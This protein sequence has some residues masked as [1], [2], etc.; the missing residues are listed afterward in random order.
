[1][2][3]RYLYTLAHLKLR[4]ISYRIFYLLRR[5]LL[6]RKLNFY[7]PEK[8]VF[9]RQLVFLPFVPS[10]DSF[11]GSSFTFLNRGLIFPGEVSWNFSE[12]G[13]LWCYNLNYFDYLNN[14]SMGSDVGLHLIRGFIGEN[15]SIRDGFEPYPVSL[16]I[17]NW[18]KFLSRHGIREERIDRSLFGQ[19]RLL[20]DNLEYHL[21]GNHLLENGFALLFAAIYFND[22]ELYGIATKILRAELE[23]QV[24]SDGAHFELSP[25]YHQI[26]LV[27]LLDCVNLIQ[28]NGNNDGLLEL[29]RNKA[30]LMLGW[31][32]QMSFAN[33][34]MPLLNDA[35]DGIAPTAHDLCSY[36]ERLGIEA[37]IVPLGESGYRKFSRAAYEMIV[38]VGKIGP[39]YIPGHAHSDT[40]SFI[41][42]LNGRPLIVD[43]GTSTYETNRRREAERRT[44]AHN[45][46]VVDDVDQSEVWGSFRVAQRAYVCNL[47]ESEEAIGAAHSGYQR[48]G[49]CHHRQFKFGADFISITDSIDSSSRHS[50]KAFFHFHPD[51]SIRLLDGF[52]S[53]GDHRISFAGA[54]CVK[55]EDYMFAPQFNCLVPAKV[56]EV[57]FENR[58]QTDIKV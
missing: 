53:A 14:E 34:D 11:D 18:I 51:V 7:E 55:L 15:D 3:K 20:V 47:V 42:Y 6:P 48:I 9:S 27:R 28:H 37:Y 23:E 39:D 17:I 25:M 8:P 54:T 30:S 12:Y 41:L 50:C 57:T 46:V 45:T 5:K 13:K 58:L 38:D 40:L 24:L 2:I 26:I 19:A 35:A 21:L 52:V 10:Y 33:G 4:Q 44:S 49:V 29:L 31:L 43:T 16:R 56:I 32:K 1:M 22:S 36:A